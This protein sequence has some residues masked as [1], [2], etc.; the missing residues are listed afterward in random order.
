MIS[1]CF[2]A[3]I[4]ELRHCS[5]E[6]FPKDHMALLEA[7]EYLFSV[8]FFFFFQKVLTETF[9]ETSKKREGDKKRGMCERVRLSFRPDPDRRYSF[10]LKISI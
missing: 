9:S 1:A 4:A 3:R 8:F 7:L 6:R 5:A 10:L 2:G